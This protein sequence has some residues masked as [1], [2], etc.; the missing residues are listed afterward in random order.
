MKIIDERNITQKRFDCV[1]YGAVFLDPTAGL[2]MKIEVDGDT[3]VVTLSS[4]IAHF[5]GSI[6]S[7]DSMVTM[8]EATLTIK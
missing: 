4:G 2:A 7:P 1:P 6:F 3:Y 8:V 5:A